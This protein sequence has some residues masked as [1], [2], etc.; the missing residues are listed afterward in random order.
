[1]AAKRK[2]KLRKMQR[3]DWFLGTIRPAFEK[4]AKNKNFVL[5]FSLIIL[6]LAGGL[7]SYFYW[8]EKNQQ[9]AS[10]ALFEA[11]VA[12]NKKPEENLEQMTKIAKDYSGTTAAYE[13]SLALSEYWLDKKDFE[14]A[15]EWTEKAIKNASTSFD[16]H[17]A[18][19]LH[20]VTLESAQEFDQAA[21]AYRKLNIKE[22]PYDFIRGEALLGLIRVELKKNNV[23]GRKINAIITDKNFSRSTC[24]KSP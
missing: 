13:A 14:K 12:F 11:Q 22:L 20:G 4:M 24:I 9:K 3:P 1:M 8:A 5:G 10:R 23:A 7:L 21:Q 2:E 15:T 17:M 16:Q 18:Q 6:A 19:Y